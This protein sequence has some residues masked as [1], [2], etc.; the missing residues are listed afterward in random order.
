METHTPAIT[1]ATQFFEAF[2]QLN[3]QAMC[4]RYQTMA[5][6]NDPVFGLLHYNELTAMWRMLCSNATNFSLQYEPPVAVDDEYVTVNWVATY[7]F[8]ATGNTVVN[9]VK[10]FIRIQNGYITEQSDAFKLSRWAAQALGVKGLLFGWSGFVQKR[11]RKNAHKALQRF[12]Q[13]AM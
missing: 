11:I 8:S 1:V 5:V 3:A 12:M 9:K 6:F 10:S 2:A 7:T 13:Q 4:Q